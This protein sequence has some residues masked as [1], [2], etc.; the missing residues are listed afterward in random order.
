MKNALF[1]TCSVVR[2]YRRE[3]VRQAVLLAVANPDG[4]EG[5]D[6]KELNSAVL[7]LLEKAA[8]SGLV[9]RNQFELGFSMAE[10]AVKDSPA[11]LKALH[12][13]V[14]QLR[15]AGVELMAREHRQDAASSTD[16]IISEASEARQSRAAAL[17]EAE[18]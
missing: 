16:S 5:P 9:L 12:G 7:A 13:L 10:A 6:R 17:R 14:E 1:L 3:F 11:Q 15:G 2:H 18:K 4:C 8:A